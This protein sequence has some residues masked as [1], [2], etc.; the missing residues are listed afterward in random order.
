MGWSVCLVSYPP[1]RVITGWFVTGPGENLYAH[2]PDQFIV[3]LFGSMML[4]SYFVYMLPTIWFG[5]RFSNLTHRGIIRKGP[6]A[7]VRHPAYAAKNFAWWC[8]GFPASIYVMFT[9]SFSQGMMYIAGLVVATTIY[10]WRAIT[11]ERHLSFDPDYEA[12]C[13]QVKYRFI[14]GVI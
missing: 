10:Y 11:E 5:V 3:G 7:I 12:Y 6:F 4:I 1:F 13:K 9:S 14:P 8:V 2:I